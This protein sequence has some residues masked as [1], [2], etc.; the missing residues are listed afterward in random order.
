MNSNYIKIKMILILRLSAHDIIKELTT[1]Q[2]AVSVD[3]YRVIDKDSNDNSN[4]INTED[5]KFTF[6]QDAHKTN[7]FIK[8]KE[9]KFTGL[10]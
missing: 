2:Y 4:L 1:N 10:L 5:Y 7:L 8:P 6:I 3:G 9:N